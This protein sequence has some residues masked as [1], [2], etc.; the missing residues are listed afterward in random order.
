[1]PTRRCLYDELD[2]SRS[3]DDADIKRAY[4]VAALR[5]HPDKNRGAGEAEASERFKAVQHAYE[6]LS[7]PHERSWYDSHRDSFIA[8]RSTDQGADDEAPTAGQATTLDLFAYFSASAYDAFDDAPDSFYGVYGMVFSTLTAEERSAGASF[9]CPSFGGTQSDWD[10]VRQFYAVYEGFSSRKSFGFADKWNLAEAPN[11]DYRRAM[12]RENKRERARVK[13]EFNDLVRELV[14]F[15]KKRDPRVKARKNLEAERKDERE[16]A[17]EVRKTKDSIERKARAADFRAQ[18]DAVLDEDADELDRI[19]EQLQLDEELDSGRKTHARGRPVA[20][21]SDSSSS[22]DH[23]EE[24]ADT[25]GDV[26]NSDKLSADSQKSESR[27]SSDVLSNDA[28]SRKAR[29][30]D[31][32]SQPPHHDDP[33]E[34][35]ETEEDDLY[36]FACKKL[37]RTSGQ[38]LNHEKSK[39]HVAAAKKL[40]EKLVKEDAL[41]AEKPAASSS[42][43]PCGEGVV[44]EAEEDMILPTPKKK[45]RKAARKRKLARKAMLSHLREEDSSEEIDTPVGDLPSNGPKTEGVED[46]ASED[47]DGDV[48]RKSDVQGPGTGT[49]KS[50][51]AQRRRQKKASAQAEVTDDAAALICNVCTA[52]F[53]SRNKL[54]AHVKE[55]GHAL[56]K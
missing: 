10:E 6:I 3:A 45:D 24:K 34:V 32:G 36:C 2:L 51:K 22:A 38:K 18:R 46:S 17:A 48:L 33:D 21:E 13:K 26:G 9:T 27:H 16:K 4:R 47:N 1:M 29:S 8:G 31:L 11:R 42:Q 5:W 37:F 28:D 12:E 19:L 15:V 55:K 50:K 44:S 23:D 35:G 56:Y 30:N 41:F 43:Q 7:D 49:I 25:H 54:F 40:R 14:S 53:P 52:T 20:D 39:K